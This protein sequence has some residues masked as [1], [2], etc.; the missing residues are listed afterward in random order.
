MPAPIPSA[1]QHI[2][3]KSPSY[4]RKFIAIQL[5]SEC[6][7]V[8]QINYETQLYAATNSKY[9]EVDDDDDDDDDT[10]WARSMHTH[11]YIF[12]WTLDTSDQ[13]LIEV[14][15]SGRLGSA[16]YIVAALCVRPFFCLYCCWLLFCFNSYHKTLQIHTYL[17]H[18]N[19]P[20]KCF[21]F[22]FLTNRSISTCFFSSLFRNGAFDW[23]MF[24][25]SIDR[26]IDLFYRLSYIFIFIFIYN[27]S[28]RIES[29]F[30][31]H[32]S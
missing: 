21:N 7:T 4:R 8:A 24:D 30:Q 9:Y 18:V 20:N 13:R 1:Q 32:K 3:N 12:E 17:M 14:C 31:I 15:A 2:S 6:L 29:F 28:S 11:K 22:V 23:S 27:N 26:T 16:T 10:T 25:R 5:I 19:M